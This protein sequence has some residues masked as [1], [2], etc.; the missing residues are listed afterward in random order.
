MRGNELWSLT[1]YR[2]DS[3][4]RRLQPKRKYGREKNGAGEI[5]LKIQMPGHLDKPRTT[6]LAQIAI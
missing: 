5:C 4:Y 1:G 3:E 2:P 6:K